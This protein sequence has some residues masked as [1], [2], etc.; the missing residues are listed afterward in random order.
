MLYPAE[1]RGQ[2]SQR[3][4]PGHD[5]VKRRSLAFSLFPVEGSPREPP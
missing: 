1:L 3:S 4:L 5:R 2:S